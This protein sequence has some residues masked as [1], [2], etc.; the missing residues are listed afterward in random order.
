MELIDLHVH[1]NASDGSFTP[2]EL[3]DYFESKHAFAFAL[4]DHDTVAGIPEV[5]RA[6]EGRQVKVIPG[7]EISTGYHGGDVHILGLDINWEKPSFRRFTDKLQE[8]R[9]TRNKRMIAKMADFGFDV[10]ED[11]IAAYFGDTSITRAHFARYL[12][13]KGYV[14]SLTEA[15]DKYLRRGCPCYVAKEEITIYEA[16]EIIKEG[17]G[18]PVL[19]HPMLYR[20]LSSEELD[21]LVADLKQHGLIGIETI[22]SENSPEDELHTRRLAQKY[23]LSITGGSDFHGKN[24][25]SIDILAGKGNLVIPK[26]LLDL[27]FEKANRTIQG[28]F[29]NKHEQY[30]NC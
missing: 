19:A 22:Y 8:A 5:L 25:P 10:S 4:T 9:I 29:T 2:S 18:I 13:D 17:E 27:L 16:M 14:K 1:S 26:E 21:A 30:D 20:F 11:K 23:G 7:I 3:V 6:A 28:G 24:K 12:Y 15:F